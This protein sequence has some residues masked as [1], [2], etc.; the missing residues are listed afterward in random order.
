MCEKC[1][2]GIPSF[3]AVESPGLDA[4][5]MIL[6]VSSIIDCARFTMSA[7]SNAPTLQKQKL[8]FGEFL[9]NVHSMTGKNLETVSNNLLDTMDDELAQTLENVVDKVLGDLKKLFDYPP[10]KSKKSKED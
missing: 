7:I 6:C 8:A 5:N 2:N 10:K 3:K 4:E 1:R 9:Y